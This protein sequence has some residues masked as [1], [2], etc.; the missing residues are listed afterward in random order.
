MGRGA[1]SIVPRPVVELLP[2][3][4]DSARGRCV[5]PSS[6]R[7]VSTHDDIS[8][9][10][11]RGLVRPAPANGA[12][13]ESAT[14]CLDLAKS[15]YGAGKPWT[16][17]RPRE[18]LN[19]AI[20]ARCPQVR[21][22]VALGGRARWVRSAQFLQH[23]TFDPVDRRWVE[24]HPSFLVVTIPGGVYYHGAP[25]PRSSDTSRDLSLAATSPMM[26]HEYRSKPGFAGLAWNGRENGWP[27][28]PSQRLKELAHLSSVR[29]GAGARSSL[30]RDCLV[31]VRRYVFPLRSRRPPDRRPRR[32]G[33]WAAWLDRQV[34]WL[35]I[36]DAGVALVA[37]LVAMLVRFGVEPGA[38][39]RALYLPVTVIAPAVWVGALTLGRCYERRFLGEG[40]DEFGT[41]SIPR[42]G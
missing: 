30:R 20:R 29:P 4:R 25:D 41:S 33:D 23:C 14:M 17:T 31:W 18:Y 35:V 22:C 2:Y 11:D 39:S 12:V 32:L 38:G 36:G 40:T 10:L 42:S 37:G 3:R 9:G 27:S 28:T 1:C 21:A 16:A 6:S 19:E 7:C 24:G 13:S 34:R 15:D 5:R 26:W 8:V